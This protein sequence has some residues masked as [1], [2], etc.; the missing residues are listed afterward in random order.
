MIAVAAPLGRGT[1]LYQFSELVVAVNPV[2]V[3]FSAF[4]DGDSALLVNNLA[5]TDIGTSLEMSVS[6]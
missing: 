3:S 6:S 4:P 1:N 5:P 2:L